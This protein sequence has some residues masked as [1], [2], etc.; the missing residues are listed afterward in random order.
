MLEG[1]EGFGKDYQ[2][3]LLVPWLINRGY[4]VVETKE[5]GGTPEAER[6]R[7]VLLY[8]KGKLSA[9]EELN[10]LQ[11]A[12]KDL[13][14]KVIIPSLEIGS[15]VVSKRG[16]P[17]TYAYQ[18]FGS[19][20]DLALISNMSYIATKGIFPDLLFIIDGDPKKGL[21]KEIDPDRFAAKGLEYHQRVREGYLD[22]AKRYNEI[23]VVIP[24]Q[25]GNP[26]VMQLEIR[27]HIKDRL[28]I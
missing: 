7:K 25:E 6:I 15:V 9:Q 18:G 27:K 3:S 5:P 10:L 12:R 16:F 28:K 19:G 2:A 1:G 23:S 14:E 22:F 4:D 20:M 8:S 13:T 11:E 17:S 24:Y 26:G 21:A